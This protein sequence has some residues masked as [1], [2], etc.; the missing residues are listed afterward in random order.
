MSR[1][2]VTVY[3]T[4]MEREAFESQ[5]EALGMSLSAYLRWRMNST[6]S[7]STTSG[8]NDASGTITFNWYPG[9]TSA[10]QSREIK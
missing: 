4:Q 7:W 2:P 9:P 5:A 6:G 8:A 10:P 1:A 3:L